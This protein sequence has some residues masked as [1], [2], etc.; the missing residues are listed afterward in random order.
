MAMHTPA[1]EA[2]GG[3]GG[4]AAGGGSAHFCR[5]N[6][7]FK[8]NTGPRR[9]DQARRARSSGSAATWATI[10]PRGRWTGSPSTFDPAVTKPQREGIQKILTHL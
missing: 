2:H 10:S 8:V 6:N 4:Q 1:T 7:A 5:A 9:R 3:A